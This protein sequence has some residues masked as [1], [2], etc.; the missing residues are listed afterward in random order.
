MSARGISQNVARRADDAFGEA[1]ETERGK[2]EGRLAVQD[3]LGD[4]AAGNGPHREAVT[5]EA[6][7]EHEAA[8]LWDLAEDW[9]EIGRGVDVARPAS[10][11]PERRQRRQQALEL[12]HAAS[13]PA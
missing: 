6:G 4:E 11:D 12:G 13:P 9:N 10:R 7:R 8:E 1:R 3:H 5:A 2:V